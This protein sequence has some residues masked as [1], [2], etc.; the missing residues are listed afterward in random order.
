MVGMQITEAPE[1]ALEFEGVSKFY[2]GDVKLRDQAVGSAVDAGDAVADA[3]ADATFAGVRGL[4]LKIK[5]GEFFA[6]L[7]PSGCGKTTCLRLI[8]G[9]EIPTEGKIK[10]LGKVVNGVHPHKRNVHMVFQ[11]YALFPHL[12]VFENVA[13]G[14]RMKRVPESQIKARVMRMLEMVHL[15]DYAKRSTVKLSGGEQQRVALVRALVNEPDIL[16]LDE[17]LGAL[18][19][20]L[21]EE[22]QTELLS[23]QKKLGITFIFVTHDQNEALNLSDRIAIMNRG[24]VIQV[25]TPEQVYDQPAS[26]FVARFVG[27]SNLFEVKPGTELFSKVK[28]KDSQSILGEKINFMIRPENLHLLPQGSER[29]AHA[30][31]DCIFKGKVVERVFLGAS[32]QYRVTLP[33]LDQTLVALVPNRS[34]V[35]QKSSLLNLG[36]DVVV[37]W[38][39][40]DAKLF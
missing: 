16:L 2:S 33:E 12:N 30:I 28:A 1:W 24:R 6:I 34:G 31:S 18:D 21:R 10:L 20:K 19:Q 38:N 17:P 39:I 35:S 13:F 9:L 23:L 4:S 27:A 11:K 8:S 15:D 37:G 22:M 3:V 40:Q 29:E 32:T 26:E 25:G 5:R 36:A 14:L 7:G